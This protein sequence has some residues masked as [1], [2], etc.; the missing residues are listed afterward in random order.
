MERA[1]QGQLLNLAK[2]LDGLSETS[3]GWWNGA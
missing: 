1:G 2:K 3:A